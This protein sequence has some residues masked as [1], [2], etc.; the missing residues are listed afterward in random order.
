M[1]IF[2]PVKMNGSADGRC[3]FHRICH[4][5]ACKMRQRFTVSG[6][7]DFNPSNVFSTI[8]KNTMSAAMITF[9]AM[10]NPNHSTNNGAMANTGT[11]CEPITYG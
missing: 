4:R 8:A 3:T 9:D 2:A 6:S 7:A 10:P 1:P 5:L 11:V